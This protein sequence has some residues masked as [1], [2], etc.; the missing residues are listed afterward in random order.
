MLQLKVTPIVGLPQFT[1]WSQV[2]ESTNSVNTRLICVFAVSGKH[3]GNV[4][5][6]VNQKISDFYFYDVQQTHDF[7]EQLVEFVRSNQCQ[8]YFSCAIL[9]T[10]KSVFATYA[11]S[12]F[13]KRGEKSG[14][15]LESDFDV[16]IVEGSYTQTDVFVLTTLQADQFLNEIQQKFIQGYE[17]DIIITSIV[18]GLHAQ[19]NSSLSA[20]VFISKEVQTDTKNK[21]VSESFI[22]TEIEEIVDEGVSNKQT[23]IQI[24]AITNS[25]IQKPESKLKIVSILFFSKTK[26]FLGVIFSMLMKILSKIFSVIQQFKLKKFLK[27]IKSIKKNGVQSVFKQKVS[28][29]VEH[30]SKK[31]VLKLFGVFVIVLLIAVTVGLVSYSRK[32]ETNR[33]NSLLQPLETQFIAS[34]NLAQNDPILAKEQLSELLVSVQAFESENEKSSALSTVTELKTQIQELLT[35]VSGQQ[36]LTQLDTFYDLRLVKSDFIASGIDVSNSKLLLFDS[37]LKQIVQ[38][39]YESK[40]VSVRDF[41]DKDKVVSA[42]ISGDEAFVLSQGVQRF[43]L[44]ENSEILEVRESGDSNQNGTLIDAYDRFVYIVNPEKRNIY[45]YSQTDGE[46]SEPIGWMKSATGLQYEEIRSI[47][48]DGDVWLTTSDGQ[49]KKFASGREEQFSIRGLDTQFESDIYVYTHADLTQLYILDPQNSRVVILEKNGDFVKEIKSVSLGA[50]SNL[51]VSEELQTIFVVG[52]SI[53]Y[54]I[55]L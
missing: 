18:P 38:L 1:G 44:T 49:L 46:Y 17:S 53:I 16:K 23:K 30:T 10:A 7:L 33:V 40:K 47:A 2:A 8:L 12:V 50:A 54:Q 26:L 36:E 29:K 25:T 27:I 19:E 9:S 42:V 24:E 4:G 48:V 20:L 52:G 5:R 13:L 28:Y 34:Q 6:D 14:K 41:S 51:A 3:A 31:N 22:E 45:R 32:R 37:G 55:K 39:E 11:G 15:I 21:Q 35:Q 43:Q